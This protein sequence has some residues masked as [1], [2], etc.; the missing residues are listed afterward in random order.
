MS[1]KQRVINEHELMQQALQTVLDTFGR[2]DGVC[3]TTHTKRQVLH[4][5]RKLLERVEHG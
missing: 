1:D 2:T 5:I 4:E 3:V